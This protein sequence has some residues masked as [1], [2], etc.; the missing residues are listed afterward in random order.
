MTSTLPLKY[1][2]SHSGLCWENRGI[3][4]VGYN[5]GGRF[6]LRQCII[7]CQTEWQ[8]VLWRSEA[9]RINGSWATV[10]GFLEQ[11]RKEA[12]TLKDL[13]PSTLHQSSCPP[14]LKH[15]CVWGGSASHLSKN[16]MNIFS[17]KNKLQQIKHNIICMHEKCKCLILESTE[18]L[19]CYAIWG[20]V[21]I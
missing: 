14:F 2:L 10:K 15:V 6:Y 18:T 12:G 3:L 11:A 17:H 8:S 13:F 9:E 1:Q 19:L 20:T 5:W 7:K 4:W 21:I 16:Y